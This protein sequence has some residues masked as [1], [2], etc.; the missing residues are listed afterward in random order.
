MLCIVLWV[1]SR[2]VTYT[3]PIHLCV[4]ELREKWIV[5]LQ[6]RAPIF[7][8]LALPSCVWPP[9]TSSHSICNNRTQLSIKILITY[10]PCRSEKATPSPCGL[11]DIYPYLAQE[12]FS[13]VGWR[14][15]G[16]KSVEITMCP[17]QCDGQ[18]PLIIDCEMVETEVSAFWLAVTE[19][20]RR[21]F[22]SQFKW[23]PA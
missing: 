23:A 8:G 18:R 19:G 2:S 5:I 4:H 17:S 12:I 3:E 10:R 16:V 20:K 21:T 13:H 1:H 6:Q 15:V 22:L 11:V 14:P 7:P 9:L